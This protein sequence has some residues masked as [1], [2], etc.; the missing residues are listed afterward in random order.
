MAVTYHAIRIALLR[1]TPSPPLPLPLNL[2]LVIPHG[3]A[4]CFS[5]DVDRSLDMLAD[6]LQNSTFDQHAVSAPLA[7]TRPFL[8]NCNL[9][10]DRYRAVRS[11]QYSPALGCTVFGWPI[12][13]GSGAP[14]IGRYT[15]K[16]LQPPP[17]VHCLHRC[18]RHPRCTSKH[19]RSCHS[20]TPPVRWSP[21]LPD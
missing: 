7:H 15:L 19:I 6:I 18:H 8:R 16:A 12:S 1:L 5:K 10:T 20:S 13:S 2:K 11:H 14:Q 21:P 4:K 9:S 17:A 3:A